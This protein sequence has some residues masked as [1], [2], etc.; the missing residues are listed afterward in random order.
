LRPEENGWLGSGQIIP[1]GK[2]RT[3]RT[4][5]IRD[6]LPDY[7]TRKLFGMNAFPGG[8]IRM[9]GNIEPDS[10]KKFSVVMLNEPKGSAIYISNIRGEGSVIIPT[11]LEI[12][13]LTFPLLDEFFQLRDKDWPGKIHSLEELKQS[14]KQELAELENNPDSLGWDRYGGWINGPKLKATGSFHTEKVE[15]KWWLVDPDGRLFWSHGIGTV[16]LDEAT[17]I[18]EREHYFP[19]LPDSIQYKSFYSNETYTPK[20]YYKG[21]TVRMFKSYAWNLQRKYGTSWQTHTRDLAHLRLRSWGL[22]TIGGWS[23]PSIFNQSKTPY[24]ETLS[25][26]S[27]RIEGSEGQ[28]GKFPDPYDKS[29]SVAIISGVE[30]IK[31]STTDPFCIGYFVDNELFWGNDQYIAK[32]VIQSPPT[33]PAKI[34]MLEYL[35]GK[36]KT[37]DTFNKSWKTNF[38]RWEDFLE[39]KKL[40]VNGMD[41]RDFT[42]VVAN[43]YFRIIKETLKKAASDK[44]Y[45]GCR[46]DFHY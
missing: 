9:W 6:I 11:E 26:D 44:L 23:D 20:G 22:N 28:W 46:F 29:L 10:I 34:A 41:I 12:R 18:T 35:R 19:R 33:Q 32:A 43:Q 3:I 2:T 36:Y 31:K 16:M 37:L 15:G 21:R 17:P 30:R 7:Y 39:N 14:A 40:P 25:S 1:A 13:K 45:M 8:I 27:K 38:N 4:P 5:I 42:E 24:T